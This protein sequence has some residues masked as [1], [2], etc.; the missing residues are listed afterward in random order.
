MNPDPIL[1]EFVWVLFVLGICQCA[2]GEDAIE[3]ILQLLDQKCLKSCHPSEGAHP[4][5]VK[6]LL[7]WLE[8]PVAGGAGTRAPNIPIC[9]NRKKKSV[10]EAS[11]W[12]E[13]VCKSL[14]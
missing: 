6:S 1:E 8:I 10:S 14:I 11:G 3:H 9:L 2:V 4:S 5:R 12:L 7:N 13:V